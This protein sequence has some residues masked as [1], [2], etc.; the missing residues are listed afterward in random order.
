MDETAIFTYDSFMSQRLFLAIPLPVAV[1]DALSDVMVQMR[2]SVQA[3]VRWAPSQGIH[4]TL[5]FLGQHDESMVS[6]LDEHI[7]PIAGQFRPV[8]ARLG[9]IGF[10]PDAAHPRV[11]WVGMEEEGGLLLAL[12]ERLGREI[13]DLKLEVDPRPWSPH[14][15]LARLDVP[16]P[17]SAFTA[18]VPNVR[19]LVD[20][21]CLYQ[22]DLTPGGARYTELRSY[23][24]IGV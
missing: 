15:T 14:L 8:E 22:S 18:T 13:H 5:H 19:F 12:R 11:V 7:A 9:D 4:A 20:R 6:L 17:A 16:L 10:F 3:R 2:R 21:F 24:L 23:P 1:G